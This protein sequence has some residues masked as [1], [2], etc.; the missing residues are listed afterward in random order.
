MTPPKRIN[1]SAPEAPEAPRKA[2]FRKFKTPA[3]KE[4]D[5][6]ELRAVIVSGCSVYTTQ[7]G[8]KIANA[9][10]A[11]F[12]TA[13][14]CKLMELQ[15]WDKLFGALFEDKKKCYTIK[16]FE[17]KNNKYQKYFKGNSITLKS[18]FTHDNG[19]LLNEQMQTSLTTCLTN[20]RMDVPDIKSA[21]GNVFT[22][23][24]F[25]SEEE[26]PKQGINQPGSFGVWYD[27]HDFCT[28]ANFTDLTPRQGDLFVGLAKSREGKE[29]LSI[30]QGMIWSV[31]H[32]KA[33]NQLPQFK[34]VK[35]WTFD[36]TTRYLFFPFSLSFSLF[37]SV[38]SLSVFLLFFLFCLS[39]SF[40]LLLLVLRHLLRHLHLLCHLFI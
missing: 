6:V 19:K 3:Q 33:W 34:D 27:N 37:S 2:K 10:V 29:T 13:D 8:K 38:C 35:T 11:V 26:N 15:L 14:Q 22:Y 18:R 28:I 7:G 12:D 25:D 9:I 30:S 21:D 23:V 31:L 32:K 17:I 24:L 40:S 20:A 1:K 16:G 39:F 5:T 4:A 36:E